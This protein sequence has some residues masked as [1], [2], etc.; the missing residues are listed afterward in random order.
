MLSLT[1][2]LSGLVFFPQK[3]V[4]VSFGRMRPL[5]VK[6]AFFAENVDF[7]TSILINGH[8]VLVS[9]LNANL[10][11]FSEIVHLP[12]LSCQSHLSLVFS[13]SF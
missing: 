11:F 5:I 1:L 7:S 8:T 3:C 2:H 10:Y 12:T 6:L 4:D 9:P 13:P